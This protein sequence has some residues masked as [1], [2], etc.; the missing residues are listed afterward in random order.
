MVTRALL[1]VLLVS[2]LALAQDAE[3]TAELDTNRIEL[4]QTARLT[5]NIT[6]GTVGFTEPQLP[7]IDDAAVRLISQ[8]TSVVQSNLRVVGSQQFVYLVEPLRTGRLV[9]EP[10]Y[11]RIEGRR[12][13]TE[14]L[15]LEVIPG[16]G[17]AP[18][19][20][21]PGFTYTPPR[22]SFQP[23]PGLDQVEGDMFVEARV[24]PETVYQN[25]A[26]TYIFRFYHTDPVSSNPRYEPID[27]TGFLKVDLGQSSNDA[28]IDGRRYAVSEARMGLFPLAPG[29][30]KLG[31]TRLEVSTLFSMPRV[32]TTDPVPLKV[33]PLPDKGKPDDFSGAVGN[34]TMRAQLDTYRVAVGEPVTLTRVIEG[35]G[36]VDLVP[37]LPLPPL[38]GFKVYDTNSDGTVSTHTG[39]LIGIKTF[40]TALVPTEPGEKVISG[41]RF[42]YFDPEEGRYE[43]ITA[44][45]MRVQV[46]G[47]APAGTPTPAESPG[48]E[49]TAPPGL[50][51]LRTGT[52]LRAPLGLWRSPLFLAVQAL[53]LAALLFVFVLPAVRRS[54]E[55]RTVRRQARP[56]DRAREVLASDGPARALHGYLTARIG[57]RT[58]GLSYRQLDDVL[59]RAGLDMALRRELFELLEEAD[60]ARYA[61][62]PSGALSRERVGALLDKLEE[63]LP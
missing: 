28:E 18:R 26:L 48:A 1:L 36:H 21:N 39:S 62:D 4:G 20:P 40:T 22:P 12:Y 11:A 13:E 55:G 15:T 49:E 23:P 51:P 34:F 59:M 29:S 57:E 27:P 56:L 61:P 25:P 3:L 32:L 45:D 60:R 5:V 42:S 54:L 41:V 52:T 35:N 24:E 19:Q 46:T 6:G 37:D 47:T 14:P 17:G 31:P 63:A 10:I 8:S 44:P 53:P 30:Y 16:T 38:P 2:G 43:T 50:K 58:T 9:I 33:L 7:K